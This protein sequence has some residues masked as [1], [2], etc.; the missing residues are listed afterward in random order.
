[1]EGYALSR[2]CLNED[3]CCCVFQDCCY[4]LPSHLSVEARDLITSMLKADPMQRIT[5]G[6]IRRHPFFQLKLPRYIALPPAETAYQ[7]KRVPYLPTPAFFTF[8]QCCKIYLNSNVSP[9]IR[10]CKRMCQMQNIENNMHNN[11]PTCCFCMWQQQPRFQGPL[12]L[13]N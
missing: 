4:M 13:M 2:L 12:G 6:E 1:M 10:N 11:M 5:I 7:V 9:V 3:G 8:S